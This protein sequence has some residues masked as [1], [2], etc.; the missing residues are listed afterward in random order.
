MIDNNFIIKTKNKF[1][2]S[3]EGVQYFQEELSKGR[4]YK[5]IAK[6]I[7]INP[8]TL[9]KLCKENNIGKDNRRKFY[10]NERF[11]EKIDSKEKAYWLG[12]LSADGYINEDRYTVEIELEAGGSF[13]LSKFLKAIDCNK[14]IKYRKVREKFFHCYV[15]LNSKVMVKDLVSLGVI[16]NKSLTLTFPEDKKVP[17]NLKIYWILGYYD[18]DGCFC[19]WFDKTHPQR[20]AR[21]YT[22]FTGTENVLKNI[23]SFLGLNGT[24]I[25]EHN[26]LNGTKNLKY[27]ESA[28]IY[29]LNKAYDNESCIF[30]LERKYK[31]I[32]KPLL[33][34]V[35]SNLYHAKNLTAGKP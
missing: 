6:E 35:E 16:Q 11:F 3:P 19:S 21:F 23:N 14:E 1:F 13:H 12:F 8:D 17:Y 24:I 9:S 7:Q 25:D 30:C 2:L 29:W 34:E 20:K 15:H 5:S 22:S 27:T 18:G 31:N 4:S 10:F 32:V 26:C 28:S 33:L